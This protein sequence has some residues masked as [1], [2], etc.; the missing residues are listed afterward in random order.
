MAEDRSLVELLA[1]LRG[2]DGEAA[3]RV[4]D[5]FASQLFALARRRLGGRLQ[6]KV[7]PDDV[8][9]SVFKSFFRRQA[10]NH[11]DART[12]DDL[13]AFLVVLTVRKCARQLRHYRRARRDVEAEEAAPAGTDA[14]GGGWEAIAHAPTPAEAAALEDLVAYLMEQLGERDRPVLVLRLQGYAVAEISAQ[15]GRS[16]RT[17]QRVLHEV[18]RRL[19][20]LHAQDVE[21]A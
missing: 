21:G 15:V 16:E 19:Q 6:S 7:D 20:G 4:F 18:R 1:R 13:E 9:Q 5:R 11:V 17:V 12:W 14:A 10:H 3:V 2:G 8:L